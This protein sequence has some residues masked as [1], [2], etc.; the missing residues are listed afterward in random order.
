[1][2]KTDELLTTIYLTCPCC[3]QKA[4]IEFHRSIETLS[5]PFLKLKMMGG[6]TGKCM[7]CGQSFPYSNPSKLYKYMNKSGISYQRSYLF[8]NLVSISAPIIV[9]IALIAIIST[10]APMVSPI[11][12]NAL[13]NVMA[14]PGDE[15]SPLVLYNYSADAA[16]QT[17][18]TTFKLAET[19]QPVD[20]AALNVSI[21]K[22]G[23]ITNTS[24]WRYG[25]TSITW[26]GK[27]HAGS[28]LGPNDTAMV[29]VNVSKYHFNV[30]DKVEMLYQI[31][32][33][34]AYVHSFTVSNQTLS[35]NNTTTSGLNG[36]TLAI[37]SGH[38]Y[39]NNMTRTGLLL[40]FSGPIT[41][42]TLISDNTGHYSISLIPNETYSIAI[43]D[44]DI[45]GIS[46]NTTTVNILNNTTYDIRLHT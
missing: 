9:L 10:I 11:L 46:Y 21:W 2:V 32:D 20:M 4:E 18:Y 3:H 14:A 29:T 36:S 38:V 31:L 35:H 30:T 12:D 44:P 45:D 37:L 7:A 26:T 25:N 34:P 6:I 42:R 8:N 40:T 28:M 24:I 27:N 41:P 17:I 19:S 39:F 43:T 1:M 5:V 23:N 13:H 22:N 16:N 33:T 15:S